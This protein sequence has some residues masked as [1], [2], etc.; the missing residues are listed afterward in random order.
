MMNKRLRLPLA[1]S[2]ALWFLVSYCLIWFL[3]LRPSEQRGLR[4]VLSGVLGRS[5]GEAE[6]PPV[7]RE[8]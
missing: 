2:L 3:I 1:L 4:M 6:R 7:S 5:A 8:E